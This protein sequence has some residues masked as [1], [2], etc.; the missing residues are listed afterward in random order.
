MNP[1]KHTLGLNTVRG[2]NKPE[3]ECL[4]EPGSA[5]QSALKPCHVTVRQ[6]LEGTGE[7]LRGKGTSPGPD[8]LHL[9]WTCSRKPSSVARPAASL[10]QASHAEKQ[11]QGLGA[12]AMGWMV[13]LKIQIYQNFRNVTLFGDGVI[14]KMRSYWTKVRPKSN[15]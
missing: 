6:R 13:F 12:H 14:S 15:I 1:P 11:A 10:H 5:S 8:K 2:F 3:P 9:D 4:R 7:H